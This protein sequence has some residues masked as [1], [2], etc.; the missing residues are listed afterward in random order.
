MTAEPT[1]YPEIGDLG[2]IGDGQSVALLGPDGH[3]EFFCPLRF[4]APPLIWPLL[5]RQRGG[6]LHITPVGEVSAA[7]TYLPDTA[8]LRYDY[9]GSHGRARSTIAMRWPAEPGVQELL[10]LV[11]GL[12]GQMT[13]DVRLAPRPDFGRRRTHA[14][15]DRR[16]IS[17]T[18]DHPTLELA[19]PIAAQALA[20]AAVGRDTLSAG[21]RWGFRL[22]VA[23]TA[24][25]P[26]PGPDPDPDG[27]AGDLDQTVQA[28]RRWT[29]GIDYDG[30][31]RDA[32]VRSTITLKLLI[33]AATGA[34]VAAGTT[35]LP[36]Q[37]GGVRNWDYRYTWLR[38]ASFTLNALYSVGCVEEARAYTRWL[39][40]TTGAHGLPLRV[41]YGIDGRVEFPEEEL[42]DLDGYRGSRPVRV[43]NGAETQLQLDSYGELLDCL[44][45]CQS[46]GED[47]M[48]AEWP[49]F[50]A[51]WSSS[52]TT[53]VSRTAASGRSAASRGT[54]CTPRRWPG[55]RWTE[56][57]RWWSGTAW[58]ATWAG[59]AARPPLCGRRS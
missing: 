38:D 8:V 31:A 21:Q 19:T 32:V 26:S 29:A 17:Y 37:I 51:W 53:G 9:T 55:W 12:E 4:D 30:P 45:I 59:G 24:L 48:R 50:R 5:D 10:W 13:F 43:G 57:A 16:W 27:V 49:H 23:D 54:S 40:Q 14:T 46:V 52:P 22:R 35:S 33:Y 18:G 47:V 58:T 3:V 1:G 25:A 39:C 7:R 34:V 36:E 56:A 44:T 11:E 28:W 20:G 15:L 41:L 2:V 6:H 42:T